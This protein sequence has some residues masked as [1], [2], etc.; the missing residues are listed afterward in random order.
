MELRLFCVKP[1]KCI[2]IILNTEMVLV[3]ENLLSW[4]LWLRL[5]Y[6]DDSMV[7]DRLATQMAKVSAE[8]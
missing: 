6:I 7:A 8:V 5:S 1:L 2:D 4:K 3:V